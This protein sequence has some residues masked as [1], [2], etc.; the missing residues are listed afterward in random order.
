MCRTVR[1]QGEL[2]VI[3]IVAAA[4]YLPLHCTHPTAPLQASR[5]PDSDVGAHLRG[6]S[7]GQ[8]GAAGRA[9]EAEGI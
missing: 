5:L 9:V 6:K 4:A 3:H 2:H 7:V 1:R 8:C